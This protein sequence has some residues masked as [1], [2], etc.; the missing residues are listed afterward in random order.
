M[1]NKIILMLSA[2]LVLTSIS[3]FAEKIT[4]QKTNIMNKPSVNEAVKN[5]LQKAYEENKAKESNPEDE[6][7]KICKNDKYCIEYAEFL[8]YP[9]KLKDLP[10]DEDFEIFL[11]EIYTVRYD[12]KQELYDQKYEASLS[13]LASLT[14]LI[15]FEE[16]KLEKLTKFD[17]IK[18]YILDM[19]L[20]FASLIKALKKMKAIASSQKELDFVDAF[21]KK[22]TGKLFPKDYEKFDEAAVVEMIKSSN[23]FCPESLKI[24]YYDYDNLCILGFPFI[25]RVDIDKKE[26]KKIIKELDKSFEKIYNPEFKTLP[27][28]KLEKIKEPAKPKEEMILAYFE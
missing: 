27:P 24:D 18:E 20:P 9:N 19:P 8:A 22:Y 17:E 25:I 4:A 21:I 10:K 15:K 14:N 5:S 11:D 2:A 28:S 26:F 7:K 6:I 16:S 23:P 1:K 3:A 12:P 13:S